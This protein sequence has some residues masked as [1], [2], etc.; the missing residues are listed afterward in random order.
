MAAIADQRHHGEQTDV[1]RSGCR[2]PSRGHGHAGCRLPTALPQQVQAHDRVMK[3]QLGQHI[4]GPRQA[5][6][7]SLDRSRQ[8]ALAS[9]DA[10]ATT[11]IPDQQP[12]FDREL[13]TRPRRLCPSEAD[14]LQ[15]TQKQR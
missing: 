5:G 9:L 7:I 2:P 3:R 15:R 14:D 6:P 8:P 13:H 12:S 1:D 10:E 11:T 4:E